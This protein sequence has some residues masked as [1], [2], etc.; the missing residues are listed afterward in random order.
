MIEN[1]ANMLNVDLG[2]TLRGNK[3]RDDDDLSRLTGSSSRT[4]S[5]R[6]RNTFSKPPAGFSAEEDEIGSSI[7]STINGNTSKQQN[8][9]R[10]KD[11]DILVSTKAPPVSDVRSKYADKL[12][13]KLDGGLA[14]VESAKALR[15]D[16]LTKGDAAG[17]LSARRIA[18]SQPVGTGSKWLAASGT[19]IS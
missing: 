9:P 15:E 8:H 4:S 5:N 16:A 6:A 11:D 17:H 18:S 10:M 2:G 3:D 7:L 12:R 14:G 13:K 19:A 1:L